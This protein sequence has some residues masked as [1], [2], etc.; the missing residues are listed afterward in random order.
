[1]E[2]TRRPG[3]AHPHFETD[4]IDLLNRLREFRAWIDQ[5]RRKNVR[6]MRAY[7]ERVEREIGP[8]IRAFDTKYGDREEGRSRSFRLAMDAVSALRRPIHLMETDLRP[9]VGMGVFLERWM[10]GRAVETYLETCCREADGHLEALT[11]E[12]G[13]A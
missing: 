12:I 7:K 4:L 5:N 11:R 1:L 9:S 3:E 8:S 2:S 6:F 10:T 13:S